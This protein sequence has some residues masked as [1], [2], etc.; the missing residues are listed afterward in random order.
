M[1]AK[2][3]SCNS[4]QPENSASRVIAFCLALHRTR[5]ASRDIAAATVRCLS[6][7]FNLTAEANLNGGVFSVALSRLHGSLRQ[8]WLLAT[9]LPCGVRTFL[10]GTCDFPARP[11]GSLF[12]HSIR[13]ST[14]LVALQT[15]AYTAT[16]STRCT[17]SM[18]VS[19]CAALRTPSASMVFMPPSIAR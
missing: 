4:S 13:K 3:S 15:T 7:L 1:I 2:V 14:L 6:H 5:V 18:V 12:N 10:T 11:S 8:G 17:S 9:V 16:P 19:P